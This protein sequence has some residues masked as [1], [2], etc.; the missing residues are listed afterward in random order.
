ML[1]ECITALMASHVVMP[2]M[3]SKASRKK[4]RVKTLDHKSA[5]MARVREFVEAHASASRVQ[6]KTA[7]VTRAQVGLSFAVLSLG[8]EE[9][10]TTMW[11]VLTKHCDDDFYVEPDP[12]FDGVDMSRRAPPTPPPQ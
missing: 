2:S 8:L 5:S 1:A 10:T 4:G 7:E 3:F 11:E 12:V 9:V 6:A